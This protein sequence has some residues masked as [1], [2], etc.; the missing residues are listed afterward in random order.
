MSNILKDWFCV[1]C[2]LQFDAKPVFDIHMSF[3]HKKQ[4][5]TNKEESVNQILIKEENHCF[6]IKT[7]K[8]PE[9]KTENP[10]KDEFPEAEEKALMYCLDYISPI[11]ENHTLVTN[12]TNDINTDLEAIST[13]RK[14]QNVTPISRTNENNKT[15]A[16]EIHP[17]INFSIQPLVDDLMPPL[18]LVT[19]FSSDFL[20]Y[21]SLETLPRF[22]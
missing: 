11:N 16:T 6:K 5:R 4:K 7:E 1:I 10:V 12:T 2:S 3:V 8:I 13:V 20:S 9:I 22:S 19:S 15:V 18:E 14:D 17:I 21:I